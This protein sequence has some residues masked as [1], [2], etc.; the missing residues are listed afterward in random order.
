[1]DIQARSDERRAGSE[2]EGIST[3]ATSMFFEVPERKRT[4]TD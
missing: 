3:M 1:M 4:A 2:K